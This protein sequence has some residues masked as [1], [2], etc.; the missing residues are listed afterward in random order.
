MDLCFLCNTKLYNE[1]TQVC[2]RITQHSNETYSE[3]IAQ[4]MG[5]EIVNV[6][7]PADYMCK[8]CTSLLT[9]VGH[10]ESALK[11]VKATMLSYMQKNHEIMHRAIKVCGVRIEHNY[12]QAT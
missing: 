10:L 5:Y 12:K 4:L 3:K 9:Q 1:R 11:H 2:S 7:T 8:S 6:I